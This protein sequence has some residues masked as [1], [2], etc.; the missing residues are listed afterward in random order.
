MLIHS[1]AGASSACAASALAALAAAAA[2]FCSAIAFG[3]IRSRCACSFRLGGGFGAAVGAGGAAS[4]LRATRSRAACSTGSG[5]PIS[6]AASS[7]RRYGASSSATAGS[8]PPH[9]PQ[10]VLLSSAPPSSSAPPLRAPLS[11]GGIPGESIPAAGPGPSA[12]LSPAAARPS[13]LRCTPRWPTGFPLPL[14]HSGH[15]SCT[16]AAATCTVSR[17]A[18]ASA[19]LCAQP[20]GYGPCRASRAKAATD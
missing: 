18:F 15:S 8:P 4:P 7:T 10:P 11:P 17:P 9:R 19:F 2:L 14:T 5:T 13:R 3:R 12:L 1:S 16:P 6:R 20:Q